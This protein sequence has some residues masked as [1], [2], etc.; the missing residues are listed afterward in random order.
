MVQNAYNFYWPEE[1]VHKH[2]QKH[3]RNAFKATVEAWEKYDKKITQRDA[4][5]VV[6]ISRV[7]EAMK[8]RGWV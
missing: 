6:A 7:V 1:E 2:L 5:Y 3:M 8:L 4:T